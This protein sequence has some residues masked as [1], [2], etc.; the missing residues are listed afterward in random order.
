M[1]DEMLNRVL[2]GKQRVTFDVTRGNQT[3]KVV[4]EG[5]G[6]CCRDIRDRIVMWSPQPVWRQG[7][8]AREKL[9]E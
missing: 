5:D 1:I 9:E 3:V 4:L 6:R 7:S 2:K 8:L